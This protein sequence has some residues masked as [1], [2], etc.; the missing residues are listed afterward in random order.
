MQEWGI[1]RQGDT[2]YK[3]SR[4]KKIDKNAI[5]QMQMKQ[6]QSLQAWGLGGRVTLGTKNNWIEKIGK[7]NPNKQMQKK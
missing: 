6:K 7:I 4:R 5:K 2:R 1:G 3:Q